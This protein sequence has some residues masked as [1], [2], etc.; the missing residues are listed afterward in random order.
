[1]TRV[2][3][4]GVA[5]NRFTGG[6]TEL[7]VEADTVRRLILELDRRYPGL[8]KQVE[9][10]MAIAIDGEIYQDAYGATFGPDSE[11]CIIPKI[12]GG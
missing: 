10:S 9:D 3:L 1:M 5:V 8:G 4:S 2:T 11:V 7:E 12:S 6:V